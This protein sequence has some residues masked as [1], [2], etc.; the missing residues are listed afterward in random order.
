M[1]LAEQV[2]ALE[3]ELR[4]VRLEVKRLRQNLLYKEYELGRER[5][6]RVAIQLENFRLGGSSAWGIVRT[7]VV[8]LNTLT[9]GEDR[10]GRALARVNDDLRQLRTL[11][12]DFGFPEEID[13]E[14]EVRSCG[15]V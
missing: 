12:R 7:L 3:E 10:G 2:V 9:R 15:C 8:D 4:S 14:I 13:G 1:S 6:V 11:F 5:E